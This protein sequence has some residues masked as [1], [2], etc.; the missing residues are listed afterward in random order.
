MVLIVL[1]QTLDAILVSDAFVWMIE[2]ISLDGAHN[3]VQ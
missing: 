3:S 2:N 1:I